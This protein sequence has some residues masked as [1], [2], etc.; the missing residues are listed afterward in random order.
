MSL[1]VN[2]FSLCNIISP[3]WDEPSPPKSTYTLFFYLLSQWVD[4]T[5][6]LNLHTHTVLIY[7][8]PLDISLGKISPS[9]C[10]SSIWAYTFFYLLFLQKGENVKDQEEKKIWED[11]YLNMLNTAGLNVNFF[12]VCRANKA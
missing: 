4:V 1:A 8:V 5:R 2:M 3:V 10:S 12:K 9:G 11:A 6:D 7:A